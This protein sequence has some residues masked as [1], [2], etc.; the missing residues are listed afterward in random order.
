MDRGVGVKAR[1]VQITV[2]V[3]GW[4]LVLA[5]GLLLGR[6]EPWSDG[7]AGSLVVTL[8]GVAMVLGSVFLDGDRDKR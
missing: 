7:R 8:V 6:T 5:G 4:C 2:A 3:C 1:P